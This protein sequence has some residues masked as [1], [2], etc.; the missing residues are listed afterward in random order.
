MSDMTLEA[1]TLL[2]ALY[3]TQATSLTSVPKSGLKALVNRSSGYLTTAAGSMAGTYR[4]SAFF[5]PLIQSLL[6]EMNQ[7]LGDTVHTLL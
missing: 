7:A 3:S 2:V 6:R 5:V 4:V 1:L